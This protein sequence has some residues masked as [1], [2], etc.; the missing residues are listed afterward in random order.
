MA[1]LATGCA[2]QP[3]IGSSSPVK[4]T[5]PVG[6]PAPG[7]ST[8]TAAVRVAGALNTVGSSGVSV[9]VVVSAFA[10]SKVRLDPAVLVEVG[11]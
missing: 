10:T 3:A 5:V 9:V 8:A 7:S 6:F 2:V 11:S 4:A 1:P